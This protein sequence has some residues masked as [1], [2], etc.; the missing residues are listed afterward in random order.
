M[1]A[2]AFDSR[3]FKRDYKR[4]AYGP[5]A[6]RSLRRGV[7]VRLMVAPGVTLL[8]MRVVKIDEER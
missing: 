6:L 2:R 8:G 5:A 7:K 4:Q 1:A 3:R